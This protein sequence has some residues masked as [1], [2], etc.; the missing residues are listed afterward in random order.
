MT[1]G[2]PWKKLLLFAVP[3][4]IGNLFQQMYSTADAIMLGHF[5]GDDA[6]AAVGASTPIFFL[7]IVLLMGIAV[8]SG[9]M[10]SQ[11]HGA[12]KREELSYTIGTSITLITIL[13][14]AMMIAGPAFTRPLLTL[15]STPKG[16]M[17][18][19]VMYMNILL[20]GV[21]GVAY[22]NILSGILRSLGDAF[23]P[24]VYL[25]VA[26]LLNVVLNLFLIPRMGTPGAALGTVIAQAVSSLLC[27]RRLMQMRNVFDM[28][29]SFLIPKKSYVSQILKLGIPT[30]ASQALIAIA[31]MVV[32]PLVNGFGEMF[33]ATNVIMMRIDSIV[34]MPIFSFSNA[35]TVFTGQNVGAGK[36]DRVNQGTK[37]GALM[38][39]AVTLVMVAVIVIFG[40]F[41][42]GLFTKTTD[43][44]DL[45]S[46]LLRIIAAGFVPL[47][48]CMVLWGVIRGA[49]DAISPLWGAAI[50][51]VFVR[52]PVA[53][54]L[55][56][57]LKREEALVFS[58]LA[59][60]LTNTLISIIVYRMGRWRNKGIVKDH[61]PE[62]P[63]CAADAAAEDEIEETKIYSL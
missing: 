10:V 20:F 52:V 8:G 50:N 30:G 25:I 54:L 31:F 40:P 41:I 44:I 33:I 56:Y 13:S 59:A 26:C 47:T 12:K 63:E 17:D 14:V 57:L 55:V 58:L 36:M 38:A 9:I 51:S 1:E 60:W 39:V 16:I 3:L 4:L 43:V 7:I 15:L 21:L 18:D 29:W 35:M 6:L 5:E 62:E 61:P 27:F 49:G 45:A 28:K 11:Y 22:F 46:R 32:Q 42:A 24:L 53:Y 2:R 19:S 23:S 37:Q 48:V 34:M